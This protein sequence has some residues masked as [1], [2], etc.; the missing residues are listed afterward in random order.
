M[1]GARFQAYKLYKEVYPMKDNFEKAW[2]TFFVRP[3][4]PCEDQ[5]QGNLSQKKDAQGNLTA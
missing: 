1:N 4:M 5:A 2:D 3:S